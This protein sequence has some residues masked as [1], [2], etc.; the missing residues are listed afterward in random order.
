MVNNAAMNIGMHVYFCIR[1]LGLFFFF[2]GYTP[3]SGVAG[4]YG[5][6][7]LRFLNLLIY[8]ISVYDLITNVFNFFQS[9]FKKPLRFTVKYITAKKK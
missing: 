4:S 9:L 1:V 7:I 3:R 8:S 2:F 6:S 5:S